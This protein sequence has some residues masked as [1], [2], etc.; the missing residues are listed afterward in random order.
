M[1]NRLRK[2]TTWRRNFRRFSTQLFATMG[3]LGIVQWLPDIIASLTA[4]MSLWEPLL[5]PTQFALIQT[6]LAL[7]GVIARNIAQSEQ[8]E[9]S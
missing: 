8:D 5:S 1:K 2:T 6:L 3:T 7:G 4:S 9:A